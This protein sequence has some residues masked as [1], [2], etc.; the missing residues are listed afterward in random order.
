MWILKVS[1]WPSRPMLGECLKLEEGWTPPTQFRFI[2]SS[3]FTRWFSET[4]STYVVY[5]ASSGNPKDSPIQSNPINKSFSPFLFQFIKCNYSVSS[6]K[7]WRAHD[8]DRALL[9]TFKQSGRKRLLSSQMTEVFL[10]G[11]GIAIIADIY[12]N[13]SNSVSWIQSTR[14]RDSVQ[15]W[16]GAAS[17]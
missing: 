17:L 6:L 13:C 8:T 7:V 9:N 12:R 5:N 15:Q 14:K 3:T 11:S 1:L 10:I 4:C 2:I 16:N